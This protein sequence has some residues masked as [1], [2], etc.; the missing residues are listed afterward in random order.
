LTVVSGPIIIIV[1]GSGD[2][3]GLAVRGRA[4]ALGEA[5]VELATDSIADLQEV[6]RAATA[7]AGSASVK[8]G[9]LFMK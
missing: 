7:V 5:H 9:C 4:I 6:C 3:L 2:C 1:V 8:N